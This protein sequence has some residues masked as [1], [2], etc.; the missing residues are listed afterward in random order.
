MFP[1]QISNNITDIQNV[2]YSE[3][4][5][6]TECSPSDYKSSDFF[7]F[8]SR[9]T[10]ELT[11]VNLTLQSTLTDTQ[12]K[13]PYVKYAC[14]FMIYVQLIFT[15]L[16]LHDSHAALLL[17]ATHCTPDYICE[18]G[19]AEEMLAKLY[20]YSCFIQYPCVFIKGSGHQTPFWP[21]RPS[22]LL[23]STNGKCFPFE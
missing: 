7:C 8:F 17:Q 18:Y 3:I 4:K 16:K 6:Q 21:A 2:S 12:V 23:E 5:Y 11:K 9:E 1:C 13:S 22:I 20:I 15:Q 19:L 10:L 14:L